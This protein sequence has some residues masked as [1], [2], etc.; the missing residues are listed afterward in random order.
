MRSLAGVC[1][2]VA[3]VLVC[4][5][6]FAEDVESLKKELEQMRQQFETM[7]NGYEKAINQ[8][9]DR[10]KALESRTSPATAAPPA[11][12]SG[13]PPAAPAVAA[14]PPPSA[15]AQPVAQAPAETPSLLELVK[16][17]EP[18]ALYQRRGAGQLLFDIGVAGDFIGDLTQ[19]NVQQAQGG[20]FPGLE[21]Y[22]FPEEIELSLF[23]Q[24]DPYARAVVRF[25]ASQEQR[26]QSI[27]VTLAEAN[28]TLMT[29]P[30][31]TQAKL[32]QMRVRFGLTN[33]IHEHDLPFIDRPDVLVQFFGQD[34][35]VEKGGEAT[36]VPP[37]PFFVELLGGV[38]N[39]DNET[40]FGLGSIK[41]PLVTGRVRTFFDFEDLGAIQFGMSVANGLQP[42]RLNN[43][44][45]GWDAK[46]KYTPE[47][48]QQA[49]L[50]VAGELLYQIR[51]VE[52]ASTG[53]DTPTQTLDRF[54]WYVF[55]ET[56]PFRFGFLSRFAPGLRYDWTEY[57]TS[58][59]HQWAVEPYLSFMPSEFLRFRVGYKHTHGNTPGCC[60]NTGVGSARIKDE[61]FFQSIFILGAHPA[62]PF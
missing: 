47:G 5:P 38:F 39:G 21:N 31:G 15:P 6:A 27:D 16:P 45:L 8:L 4:S 23:G 19:N 7:K 29:L 46:Y 10:I 57:P 14:P 30:F 61:L 51:Q 17:R 48:W 37:L 33:Q 20:T 54:G 18:F 28:L 24:I 50:T 34:G 58:P 25:E 56:Q 32:G 36:W 35:L 22:I 13:A 9:G 44:V 40:A 60:T 11:A 42:D 52:V 41:N 1:F 43:L 59:G 49:L 12:G 26:G 62:H 3:G 2:L 55:G 53:S